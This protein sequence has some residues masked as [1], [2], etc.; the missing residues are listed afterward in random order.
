MRS[1]FLVICV[2]SCLAFAACSKDDREVGQVVNGGAILP[3]SNT[4]VHPLGDEFTV[5]YTSASEWD[6]SLSADNHGIKAVPVSGGPGTTSITFTVE[7]NFDE[8]YE[9]VLT[10][11]SQGADDKSFTIKQKAVVFDLKINEAQNNDYKTS[12]DDSVVFDWTKSTGDKGANFVLTSNIEWSVEISENDRY[13]LFDGKEEISSSRTGGSVIM[14]KEASDYSF[15]LSAVANNLSKGF[16]PCKISIVPRKVGLDKKDVLDSDYVKNLKKEITVSQEFL[17]FYLEG[18]TGQEQKDSY[19]MEY[20][21]SELGLDYLERFAEDEKPDDWPGEQYFDVVFEKDKVSFADKAWKE[22]D[23]SVLDKTLFVVDQ[24]DTE[25]PF[26]DDETRTV[27]RRRMRLTVPDPNTE[28]FFDDQEEKT[29]RTLTLPL[30]VDG[31]NVA[32]ISLQ[33][34]QNKYVLDMNMV[35]ADLKFGNNDG[36]EREIEITTKGPWRLAKAGTEG[37]EWLDVD[38]FGSGNAKLKITVNE[39]N[40]LLD[41]KEATLTLSTNF[42][43]KEIVNDAENDKLTVSQDEFLFTLEPEWYP[44]ESI[45]RLNVNEYSQK[46][47]SSGDWTLKMVPEDRDHGFWVEAYAIE[48]NEGR[49]EL[50]DDT[51]EGGPGEWLIYVKAK[52]ANPHEK[53]RMMNM[54]VTSNLHAGND[55]YPQYKDGIPKPFNLNQKE[56]RFEL[57]KDDKSIHDKDVPVPAYKRDANEY[58]F[59]VKCG[60][61]WKISEYPEEWVKSISPVEGD[62]TKAVDVTVTFEDNVGDKWNEARDGDIKILS[63][64]KALT[65]DDITKYSPDNPADDVEPKGFKVVQDAFVF[66]VTPHL[67]EEEIGAVDN[68][69]Y[70]LCSVECTDE[71]EWKIVGL[72]LGKINAQE[73]VGTKDVKFSLNNNGTLEPRDFDVKV[74]CDLLP[75]GDREVTLGT[76][77]QGAY[78]FDSVPVEIPTFDELENL[79]S[80]FNVDCL[81]KWTVE[82]K[83]DWITLS[84]ASGNGSA[85]PVSVTVTASKNTSASNSTRGPSNFS[86]KSDVG[87]VVH[88]KVITVSQKDYVW[89]VDNPLADQKVGTLETPEFSQSFRCSG[90]WKAKSNNTF[91]SVSPEH[92]DGGRDVNETVK[93]NVSANYTENGRTAV[94]TISSDDNSS[95]SKTIRINQEK[96]VFAV[97]MENKTTAVLEDSFDVNVTCSGGEGSW[98]HA[99]DEKAK[100]FISITREDGKIT[101]T[102]SPNYSTETDNTGVITL[103]TTDASKLTREVTVTQPKYIFDVPVSDVSFGS[104][105]SEKTFSGLECTGELTALEAVDWLT[106]TYKDGVLTVKAAENTGG[107]RYAIVTVT[108]SHYDKNKDL[109]NKLIKE[110]KVTQAAAAKK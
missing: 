104:A 32:E 102:V 11:S 93:M 4:Y 86:I 16:Y 79:T 110:F 45:E 77:R 83:P 71:A 42:G 60:A 100:K 15:N 43:D 75:V 3:I 62:G 109:Q 25:E 56:Y 82:S 92:G 2:L 27:I 99:L 46:L 20:P 12:N 57:A 88:K 22:G 41:P 59:V 65:L 49:A 84:P 108:S 5:S 13:K 94:I 29:S 70:D 38:Q 24:E 9:T 6:L 107:E 14:D 95:F 1:R 31:E 72:D 63:Y 67:S 103:S 64:K 66:N 34:Y 18:V 85:G 8:D 61:P 69:L 33:Y 48:K 105:K 28:R 47:V 17:I 90:S 37:A 35:S 91:V 54:T 26:E 80:T 40:L 7:P 74:V 87:G 10:F 101:A 30:N 50:N 97:D 68:N 73:T 98:T 58:K 81:G 51:L 76:I 19:V 52:D 36:T 44:G 106:V 96:Y 78:R 21:F 39:Q 55:R 53:E 89:R 23:V